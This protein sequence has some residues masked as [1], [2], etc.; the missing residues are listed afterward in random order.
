MNWKRVGLLIAVATLTSGF[1][2]HGLVGNDTGGM[3]PWAGQTRYEA[4][5]MAADHCAQYNKV[6]RITSVHRRYGDYIGFVCH[7]P[8]RYDPMKAAARGWYGGAIS[9]LD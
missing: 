3:I 9:T 8:R 1:G 6:A 5:A 4:R 7:F 2:L